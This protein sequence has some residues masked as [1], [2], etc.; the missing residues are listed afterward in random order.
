MHIIVLSKLRI[1]ALWS[2]AV[3]VLGQ[4]VIF[5]TENAANRQKKR[6]LNYAA[7]M[8]S[9]PQGGFITKLVDICDSH[10]MEKRS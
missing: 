4:C 8:I 1:I 9:K 10:C 3:C 2:F 6:G 5:K 7:L